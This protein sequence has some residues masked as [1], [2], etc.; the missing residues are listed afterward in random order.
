MIAK[1]TYRR[2]PHLVSYWGANRLTLEN[3]ATGRR[4]GGAPLVH[5]VLDLFDR[6]RPI[7]D[8]FHALPQYPEQTLARVFAQVLL[9]RRTWRQFSTRR[10]SLQ[11]LG[12]VLG[13][14]FRVQRWIELPGVG[15]VAFK[16]S[17]SGGARHPIECYVL[18]LRINGLPRGLYHYRPDR[19]VLERMS[20]RASRAQVASYLPGQAWYGGASVLV[21]LTAVFAR[22]QW[23]YPFARAYRVVL[24]E[25]GH[26]C[27]TFCLTAS[28]LNLAPFC[29]MALA[30]SAIE[31]DLGVDGVAESVIYA[32][33]FG[34][35]PDGIDWAPWPSRRRRSRASATTV[36]SGSDRSQRRRKSS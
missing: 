20:S 35:R 4:A 17:P 6:W 26:V 5:E 13:L 8:V 34:A 10:V 21:L 15:R 32:A 11:A 9:T 12:S 36:R 18:A 24:A 7:E 29:T 1:L 28:W 33:G 2:S 30:D 31:R 23:K 27:Q 3:Y 14:T 19:H 22:T 25:A 16:T